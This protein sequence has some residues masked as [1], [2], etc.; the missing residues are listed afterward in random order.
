MSDTDVRVQIGDQMKTDDGW[1][2][3]D[4]V[5]QEL[6]NGADPSTLA[7]K[8]GVSDDVIRRVR[9]RRGVSHRDQTP[10]ERALDPT[11]SE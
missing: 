5:A 10:T 3:K 2:D 7:E 11:I 8:Y 1:V 6:A 9:H 4:T